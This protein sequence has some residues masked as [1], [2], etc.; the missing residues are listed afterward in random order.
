VIVTKSVT[1]DLSWRASE[2]ALHPKFGE[3][4]VYVVLRITLWRLDQTHLDLRLFP[5]RGREAYSWGVTRSYNCWGVSYL[6]AP[7]RFRR[8]SPNPSISMAQRRS[9]GGFSSL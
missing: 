4:L 1:R 6:P 5:Q 7:A 3:S 9:P 2:N 8:G